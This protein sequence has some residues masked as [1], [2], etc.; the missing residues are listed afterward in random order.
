[1]LQRAVLA[2]GLL[3]GVNAFSPHIKLGKRQDSKPRERLFVGVPEDVDLKWYPCSTEVL[4]IK[5]ECARLS[6][7][8]DYKNPKNGLRAIIPI[9]KAPADPTV[10][11]K[12]SVLTNPGGPGELGTEFIYNVDFATHIA[13]HIVGPG[14]D[15]IGFDPRGIGY[16]IPYGSCELVPG[17]FEPDRQNA[18]VVPKQTKNP[19]VRPRGSSS[20]ISNDEVV[21]GLLLPDDPP[22]WKP[23]AY[24]VADLTSSQ[25]LNYTGA[26]NQ[27]SQHMNTIVVATDMLEIAKALAR[28]KHECED[29]AVVNFFAI[30]YGTVI[31][32]YFATLYPNRVG[33]FYLDGVVDVVSLVAQDSRNTTLSH[34]D[35]AWSQFF[36]A[37]AKAGPDSCSFYTG[38]N[39]HAIR[40]RFN[41]LTLKLNATR[42]ELEE[43]PNA[44]KVTQILAALKQVIFTSL[45]V[46]WASWPPV[47]DFF[48]AV[49]P[50]L[51]SDN[52]TDW[53][54]D[55]LMAL[56]AQL[57]AAQTGPTG[58]VTDIP[59]SYPQVV[60]TDS[61]DVRGEEI[62]L[63]EEQAWKQVSRI[64]GY[65]SL[66]N[67]I[68]CTEWQIRPSWEWYG[69]V[70]GA[71]KTPILFGAT[72]LDPITP[73]ENAEKARKLFKG[74]KMIYVDEV[75]HT[76]FNTRN[77]CGFSH[78]L[79]YFQDGT[80]P[81]HNNRCAAEVPPFF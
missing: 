16:S 11:Y 47:A 26:Y 17:T 51:A 24:A 31:G 32:Q 69:P 74:A 22:S 25:C 40:D 72:I 29:T 64:G 5:Y 80:L 66:S 4:P 42:Y 78:V 81:D 38:R 8:L 77:T 71:T 10:P 46:A 34:A 73:Y 6:V 36:T 53:D 19:A 7:P 79:A 39:S 30:S 62:T 49:E 21:Y 59:E 58:P 68:L 76:T 75:G 43:N 3:A 20:I 23:T 52:P 55:A 44:E 33:K 63:E 67:K 28:E 14:W 60:C 37:C 70:G 27:A 45:Y 1:M 61:I 41:A 57:V 9:I 65:T 13:S 48:V 2:L 18:T 50:L 12:G 35:K 56:Y 54:F 15:I